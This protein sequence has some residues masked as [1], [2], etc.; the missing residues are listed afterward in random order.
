MWY[1]PMNSDSDAEPTDL[2]HLRVFGCKAYAHIPNERHQKS[3]NNGSITKHKAGWVIKGFEQRY[4]IDYSETYASVVKSRTYKVA[5]AIAAYYDYHREQMD[6]KTAFLNEKLDGT[7]FIIQPT[8]Y[9]KGTLV[10]HLNKALYGLKQSPRV[11]YKTI[12]TFLPDLGF[13]CLQMRRFT[14]VCLRRRHPASR[15][16]HEGH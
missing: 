12:H 14:S 4:G 11:W 1:E 7:V 2:S 8:G 6:V 9:T 16:Q 3:A 10:C 13:G 15:P 5:I